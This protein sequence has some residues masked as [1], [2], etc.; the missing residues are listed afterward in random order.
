MKIMKNPRVLGVYEKTWIF[1]DKIS[2]SMDSQENDHTRGEIFIHNWLWRVSKKKRGD[3][4]PVRGGCRPVRGGCRPVRGLFRASRA[5]S[6]SRSRAANCDFWT[7]LGDLWR[8]ILME[9]WILGTILS[10]KMTTFLKESP[11]ITDSEGCQ[12]VTTYTFCSALLS[13]AKLNNLNS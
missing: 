10:N 7:D 13:T 11:V 6:A 3:C 12:D 4:R 8:E 5:G 1:H 9:T 2:K